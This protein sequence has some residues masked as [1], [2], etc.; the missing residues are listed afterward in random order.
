M[1]SCVFSAAQTRGEEAR[2]AVEAAELLACATHLAFKIGQMSD[3]LYYSSKR[4]GTS[5]LGTSSGNPG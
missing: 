1:P 4:H 2:K 3:C 5:Q